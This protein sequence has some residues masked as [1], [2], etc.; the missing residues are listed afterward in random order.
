MKLGT[1]SCT[2]VAWF[3]KKA[4]TKRMAVVQNMK[5][6]KDPHTSKLIKQDPNTLKA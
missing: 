4:Y 5:L 1:K 6:G 2:V 3:K